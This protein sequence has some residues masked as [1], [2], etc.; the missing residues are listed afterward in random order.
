MTH[1]PC[2]PHLRTPVKIGPHT[3]HASSYTG[4]WPHLDP[5]QAALFLDQAWKGV[6]FPV[7]MRKDLLCVEHW[8][9]RGVVPVPEL[10]SLVDWVIDR[11]QEGLTVDI[12]CLGGHGRTGTVLAAMLA[13]VEALTAAAAITAIRGRYCKEA[14]EADQP[15]L[16]EEYVTYRR[17][18]G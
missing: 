12:G 15:T 18:V 16:V 1:K 13:N 17:E 10:V 11:L 3:V 14:V 6:A 7:S 4:K 2:W 9:D 8:E 5:P